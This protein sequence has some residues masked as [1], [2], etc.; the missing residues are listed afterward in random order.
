MITKKELTESLGLS[1]V[2]KYFSAWLSRFTDITKLYG[3]AFADL[4]QVFGDFS[5]GA[6]Y[7][8][9]SFLPR[10]QDVA[11]ECGMVTHRYVPCSAVDALDILRDAP[12]ETLCLIRVNTAFFTGFKRASWREDHYV[13]VNGDLAWI[14]E[15]PLAEGE[16]TEER[17]GEVFD[18]ALCL[19][20][21][22]DVDADVPDG[23]TQAFA[24][25][26]C[27][28]NRFPFGL[29]S[30]E[31]AIGVLRVTRKRLHKF[32]EKNEKVAQALKEEIA[33]LD[34]VFFDIRL[35]QLQE[36]KGE[37]PDKRKAYADL[38]EKVQAVVHA[39]KRAMEALKE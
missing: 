9:Y 39:E 18:G 10:L 32:F 8:H 15:Y 19:Y 22:A 27:A 2:E 4:N 14:N 34:K 38:C 24:A 21:A 28:V 31:S 26:T 12:N 33:L 20:A 7:Q 36:K 23:V 30:L 29:G 25:Q 3:S 1:C 35:R 17:F 37:K 16:F 6:T 11:E 5:L 13:C